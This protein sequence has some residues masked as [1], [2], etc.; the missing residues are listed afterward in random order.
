VIPNQFSEIAESNG[1]V[2]LNAS[3]SEDSTQYFWSMPSN[4]LELWAYLESSRIGWPVA[5][6]FYKERDV[7]NEE[8]R[9][10]IDSSPQGRL[11]EEFLAAAYMA[12][13]YGRPG[14]G[15]E[16]D[17]T[18]VTATEAEAF[19]KKYY[20]PANIVVAVVG[21]IDTKTAMPML[22]KYFGRIPAG[23]K[24]E[25]MTTIEPPQNAERSVV[26][27][28]ASQPIFLEGYHRPDYLD[29]DDAAYSAITDI[30]S[31]GRTSRLYRALVRD[32]K[33]ALVAEGFSGFP[34]VKF[35]GLFAFYAVPQSGHT[36]EEMGTAVHKELELLKT[37]DVSDAELER[38]KTRARADVLRS[39]GDNDGLAS[40]LADYQTR[41]GDW[42]QLFR[43]LA[44]ID[45][46]SK[47][48]IRRV[49]QKTFVASNRTTTRIEF[50]APAQ[51]E[52]A[53]ASA[54]AG[55]AQ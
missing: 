55:G 18:Q 29:P 54:P 50:Q 20:V 28:E 46:V 44:E 5:R 12:H 14:V 41:F 53:H 31:N 24:P 11:V 10:R 30:F 35:P 32:Q 19:H 8:R 47:A 2:D 7:V 25:P 48:D 51:T 43:E 39:L 21:D 23:P 34:G 22:E 42:R 33:I 40:Q 17:I 49:A 15:W 3:T 38:F 16:S 26:L 37:T 13:P 52:G 6:E 27:H 36:A 9:M 1:A 4:R 45:A